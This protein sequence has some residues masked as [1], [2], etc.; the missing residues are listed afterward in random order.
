MSVGQIGRHYEQG[1]IRHYVD[2]CLRI[3]GKQIFKRS[4]TFCA[5]SF[6]V[7]LPRIQNVIL[8]KRGSYP[9]S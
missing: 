8:L 4:D 3:P 2:K 7:R 9:K 5:R 6:D 1:E